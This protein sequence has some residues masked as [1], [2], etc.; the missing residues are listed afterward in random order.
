MGR[1]KS[2]RATTQR[3]DHERLPP[4]QDN[5]FVLVVTHTRDAS[6]LRKDARQYRCAAC[7]CPCVIALENLCAAA[8]GELNPERQILIKAFSVESRSSKGFNFVCGQYTGWQATC[9]KFVVPVGWDA[10]PCTLCH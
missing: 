6:L 10:L 1:I 3:R 2:G 5:T 4:V 9:I 7:A 8:C